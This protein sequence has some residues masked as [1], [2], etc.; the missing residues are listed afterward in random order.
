MHLSRWVRG[1]APACPSQRRQRG[2]ELGSDGGRSWPCK[3]SVPKCGGKSGV[4][5]T[6]PALTSLGCRSASRKVSVCRRAA[7]TVALRTVAVNV[8]KENPKISNP[9]P[10]VDAV[11]GTL[12]NGTLFSGTL[13]S[14]D[15][16]QRYPCSMETLFTGQVCISAGGA[17]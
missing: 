15:P 10:N 12:L 16:V 3:S 17:P 13:F 9:Y 11:S 2:K 5:G 6:P 8:L 14:G 1:R 7:R 4:L